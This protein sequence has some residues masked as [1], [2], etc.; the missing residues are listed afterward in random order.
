MSSG[1]R[2]GSAYTGKDIDAIRQEAEQRLEQRRID[3]EVNA[4]LQ[5]ELA[6]VSGRDVDTV[7][8]RLDAIR[9]VLGEDVVEV[10]RLTFGGSVAKHTYV[11]GLSDVDALLHIGGDSAQMDPE[12]LR[13]RIK[14]A[15]EQRLPQGEIRSIEAGRMAVTVTYRDGNQVQLVPAVSRGRDRFAVADQSGRSWSDAIDPVAFTRRLTEVNQQQ[16]GMVVPTI[17]LAKAILNSR[18]GE[19][20]PAGYHVEALAVDAFRSYDG[21]RTHKAMLGRLLTSAANGVLTP[22]TDVTGQSASVDAALGPAGSPE[23]RALARQIENVAAITTGSSSI[24]QW[25]ALF[26]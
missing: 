12:Q 22:A 15:L 9:D 25:K 4:L 13:E 19:N 8:A 7:N 16:G 1:G 20:A 5:A 21:P 3:A 23:R 2:S 24:R 14:E 6:A 11:D 26:E 18:L 10:D 17:K